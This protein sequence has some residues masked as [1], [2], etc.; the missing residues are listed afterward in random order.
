M[1]PTVSILLTLLSPPLHQ[2]TKP[3]VS[4]L[5]KQLNELLA[6][7]LYPDTSTDPVVAALRQELAEAEAAAVNVLTMLR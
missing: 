1:Y 4:F 2:S 7:G 5:R 6:T 3:A